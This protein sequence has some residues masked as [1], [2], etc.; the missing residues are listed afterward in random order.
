MRLTR[1]GFLQAVGVTAGGAALAGAPSVATEQA[2]RDLAR[3]ATPEE[4]WTPSICQQCPAGCG[5][6]V[7]TMDGEAVGLR[8]NPAHPVNR[9]AL[10]P[11]PFGA[12][13][14]LHDT[15]RHR[16][17]MLREGERGSGRFKSIG[18]DE[19]LDLVTGRLGDLRSQ[20][21]AHTVVTLGGQYRGLRDA[22][23]AR[24]TQ[25]YGTP[26]YVRMRCPA[27]ERPTLTTGCN[28]ATSPLTYDLER[29]QPS[30]SS[31]RD[32][33]R[34]GSRPWPPAARLPRSVTAAGTPGERWWSWTRAGRFR[35]R[36]PIDGYPSA[37]GP[38]ASSPSGSPTCSCGRNSTIG[39]SSSARPPGSRTGRT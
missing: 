24:F 10:C 8:G 9:G 25:A 33:S 6:L 7:R 3:W 37:R 26:N 20:G 35:R 17:P 27:P 39:H 23:W 31:G 2:G 34:A 13:Q 14:A 5:L 15:N 4:Q 18:W 1:R 12:L 29:A 22:L 38:T 32:C 30:S 21:L 36:R 16:G 11:K 28:G 19:A